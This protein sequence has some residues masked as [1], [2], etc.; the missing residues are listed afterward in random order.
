MHL[1]TQLGSTNGITLMV[2]N[3]SPLIPA[4]KRGFT[5]IELL[6][7]IAVIGI[8]VA[9][10]LPAVQQAR[11][12]A[13]RTQC[14]NN[15]KQLG[16]AMHI[17]VDAFGYFPA[18]APSGTYYTSIVQMMPSL[19]PAIAQNMI[20]PKGYSGTP[21][22]FPA[23]LTTLPVLS[24]PSDPVN[25]IRFTLLSTPRYYGNLSYVG[26]FGW[27]RNA[28]GYE[29]E[30]MMTASEWPKPNGLLSLDYDFNVTTRGAAAKGDPRVKVKP[31]HA[32]D[33]LSN[34][35]A[36]SERLKN[37]GV[38]YLDSTVPDTRVN[39]NGPTDIGMVPLPAMANV[40]RDLPITARGATSRTRGARWDDAY[41]SNNNTYNHLMG[42]NERSCYFAIGGSG[43]ADKVH[44]WDGDGGNTAS[45]MHHGGVN[46]LMGDGAVRF[47]N[48]NI[49][50]VVWW[51]I[52][53]R[54]D[55]R[56]LGEF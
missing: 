47:V 39:Y 30:R 27:P 55:G 2:R 4:R 45:S 40:C 13:R 52:G 23:I 15:L 22:N 17:H 9:L 50:R 10:L 41:V 56:V 33:G 32:T 31:G 20:A 24:C 26:N 38:T 28:T 54:D 18:T 35:A 21:E 12:A 51:A 16:L 14:L 1:L 37:D 34:T 19:D 6:V 5:L 36:Y 7:V 48:E 43:W 25:N 46:V 44:E 11:E 3:C 8:L 42:P 29:G 53:A 49:D